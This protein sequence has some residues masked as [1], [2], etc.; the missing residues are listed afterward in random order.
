MVDIELKHYSVHYGT[1][2]SLFYNPVK[3][4]K[5][6]TDGDCHTSNIPAMVNRGLAGIVSSL[7]TSLFSSLFTFSLK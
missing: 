6:H 3:N 2:P 4:S 1:A 5:V 7:L